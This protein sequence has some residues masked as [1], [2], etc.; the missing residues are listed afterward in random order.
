M[1]ASGP[2]GLPSHIGR[3]AVERLL[4]R[5][6]MGVVC[7]AHDPVINRKVAIKWIRTDLLSSSDQQDYIERFQ[8][9][10]QTAGRCSHPNIVS[11]YDFEVQDGQPYLVM[12]F[13]EGQNLAQ[14]LKAAGKF[15]PNDAVAVIRQVL[16]ALACAHGTGVVH[17]DVKPA[18]VLLLAGHRAKVTDFG[19]ARLEISEATQIGMVIGTPNYMSP[20]Q[21]RGDEVDSRS[22]LFSAG[23]VLYEML[24][25]TRPFAG[26]TDTETMWRVLNASP[27]PID[28]GTAGAIPG[29]EATLQRA[30]AK[31]RQD[32]FPT[33]SAMA[34]A[35]GVPGDAA[36]TVI[37]ATMT[38]VTV[39]GRP[40]TGTGINPLETERAERALA[41]YVGPI[42]R[43]LVRRAVQRISS[44][45]GLWEALA[46]HIERP[47]ER[48]AFLRQSGIRRPP[49]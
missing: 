31:N 17:R 2:A 9:E 49:R 45:A 41:Q 30:L 22:D 27:P 28:P 46:A 43:V 37:G 14:T 39:L 1:S 19:I 34:S 42:A 6:A 26:K 40:S 47:D 23:V 29:L 10:A 12:E 5:G 36:A 35:L 13:V 18:N 21:C 4:G 3:Y 44:A 16:D 7:L 25:G 48:A 15:A 11:I 32:R 33:A 8:R 38:G 20:E 24:T